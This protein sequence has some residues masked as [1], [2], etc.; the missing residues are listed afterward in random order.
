MRHGPEMGQ[1]SRAD[2]EGDALRPQHT[3]SL[4]S[5]HVGKPL[6]TLRA[7]MHR[8]CGARA[9]FGQDIGVR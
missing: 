6:A 3:L 9:G 1:I 2:L 8:S 4:P 5:E 7:V